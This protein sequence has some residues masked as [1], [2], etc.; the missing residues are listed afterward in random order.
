MMKASDVRRPDVN[1]ISLLCYNV[2][3]KI[4]YTDLMK[5]WT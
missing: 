1:I 3:L 5:R 2:V 4:K